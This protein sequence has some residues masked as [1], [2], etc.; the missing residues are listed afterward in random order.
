MDLNGH[1]PNI[2]GNKVQNKKAALAYCSK[3][4]P[5]PLQFNMDIKEE[6]AAREGKRK[7][8]GKRLIEEPNYTLTQMVEE[9]PSELYNLPQW[10][11]ALQTYKRLKGSDKPDL[12]ELLPNPWNLVLPSDNETKKRHYWIWSKNPNMGKT[13]QFLEPISKYKAEFMDMSERFQEFPTNTQAVLIDEYTT[14]YLKATD[15]NRMCDGSQAYP[16]KGGP[17]ITLNK[18]LIIICSNAPMDEVY[19]NAYDKIRARFQG[20]NV[21]GP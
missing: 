5:N 16:T 10:E 12:P 2:R 8:I 3:E 18:P 14:A 9:N 13:T 6:T 4:D 11:K 7:I 17:K 21:D 1:H 15:L 19:P 20:I